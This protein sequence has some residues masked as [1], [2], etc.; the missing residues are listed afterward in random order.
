M[1]ARKLEAILMR[2][3]LNYEITRQRGSHRVMEAPG[4]PR[5]IFA[6]HDS[7]NLSPGIVRKILTKD[8]ALSEDEALELL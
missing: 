2:A 7:Q 1:K 6:F 8:V 4:R 3:P 5:L